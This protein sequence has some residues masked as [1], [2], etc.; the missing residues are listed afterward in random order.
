MR[1]VYFVITLF[2]CFCSGVG[3]QST[4]DSLK[5]KLS[6]VKDSARYVDALNRIAMLSYEVSADSTFKYTTQARAIAERINYSQ[7]RADA[8]NNL[9]VFFDIKGNLQLALRY[10]VDGGKAYE[11]IA[12]SANVVQSNMNIAMVYAA[13]GKSQRGQ[14]HFK[15][16]LA[17][18]K[19]LKK[20]S[21]LSLVIFNYLLTYPKLFTAQQHSSYLGEAQQIARRYNDN[22]V[23]L[24]IEQLYANQ[25]IAAGRREE[26]LKQLALTIQHALD[27]KFYYASMDM[28]M[29]MAEH[30]LPN[31][32]K[33]AAAYFEKALQIAVDHG[34]LVYSRLISRR[35][36]ELY[37][38]LGDH[39]KAAA[40]ATQL[41]QLEDEQQVLDNA[42]S[43]DYLDYALK[44]E[45]LKSLERRTA[46]QRW[47]L[48]LSAIAFLLVLI[49]LILIRRNLLRT[50][51]LNAKIL[52]QNN[53][54][55]GTL[56]ALEQS[57][58]DNTAII[59]IVAHDLRNPI[60]AIATMTEMMLAEPDRSEEDREMMGLMKTSAQN[61]LQLVNELLYLH[62]RADRLIKEPVDLEDMLQYCVSMLAPKA[63]LKRQQIELDVLPIQI[64]ASR[65]RLWRVISNLLANAIKFSPEGGLIKVSVASA[66][67]NVR[68]SVSDQGIGI[69]PEMGEKI[70]DLFTEGKRKGTG[71]EESFGLGL[72]ISKQI[73]EAHG[74]KIGFTNNAGGGTT[75]FVALP[76]T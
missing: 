75:F 19:K 6:S 52:Q 58:A 42:S 74:G 18:G 3:A 20:D 22:R 33:Q 73:V 72:A 63:E 29:G 38:T 12:D 4:I 28:Q 50:K 44:D 55:K 53:N 35:L 54:L 57:Q 23:L 61:S 31:A 68:I 48:G 11:L 37:Q 7:G 59:K 51:G 41:L 8:L 69:P 46:D 27:K 39:K 10:Y 76:T 56:S 60:G 1:K 9:G 62:S 47:L 43:I 66:G 16:A 36:L 24:A 2:F 21:I 45:Q 30:L 40:Y 70:F 26:G 25:L 32:P 34:Y 13:M 64:P 49:I 71:G 14:A 67:T 17:Q 15:R 65:D 5:A